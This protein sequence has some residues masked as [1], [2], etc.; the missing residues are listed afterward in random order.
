MEVES[1]EKDRL[2]QTK[3][4]T[5]PLACGSLE[6]EIPDREQVQLD[7]KAE[8]PGI[9]NKKGKLKLDSWIQVKVYRIKRDKEE[10][11]LAFLAQKPPALHQRT[12]N[13]SGE[14][15]VAGGA[16]EQP[17]TWE[18]GEGKKRA[19]TTWAKGVRMFLGKVGLGT[20]HWQRRP[21]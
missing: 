20:L 21:D 18:C 19:V 4:M 8:Y 12:L 17:E 1:S 3:M 11:F 9:R 16:K 10:T 13:E 6:E 7:C 2:C 15:E 14:E 5:L